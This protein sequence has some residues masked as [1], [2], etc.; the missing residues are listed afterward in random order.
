MKCLVAKRVEVTKEE[1]TIIDSAGSKDDIGA[2][3]NQ[4]RAQIEETL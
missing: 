4:I 3:C 1:T 2:R